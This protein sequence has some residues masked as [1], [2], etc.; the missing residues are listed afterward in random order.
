MKLIANPICL[1]NPVASTPRRGT[2]A[3]VLH[4]FD[5]S[6][7]QCTGASLMRQHARGWFVR[8]AFR[9]R[10]NVDKPVCRAHI[11]SFPLHEFLRV[12]K[13]V[14]SLAAINP[15]TCE[16]RSRAWSLVL[17]SLVFFNAESRRL[18]RGA[19]IRK[20]VAK[21]VCRAHIISFPHWRS[22]TAPLRPLWEYLSMSP[23]AFQRRVCRRYQGLMSGC[24][25]QPLLATDH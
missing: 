24:L 10:G 6:H 22:G 3:P 12:D 13:T 15:S 8:N 23:F 5:E 18:K 17:A 1:A 14:A 20:D 16:P 7:M 11:I 2:A 4:L 9:E 25:K 21:P 19:E